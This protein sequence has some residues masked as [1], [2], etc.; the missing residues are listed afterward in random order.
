MLSFTVYELIADAQNYNDAIAQLER[1]FSSAP[2]QI[3]ARYLP[4]LRTCKQSTGQSV[5]E[6]QQKLEQL[7]ADCN[8]GAVTTQEHKQEAICDTF[9]RGLASSEIR[10]R[11]LE[12]RD[13]TMQNPFNK[14]QSLKIAYGN[15]IQYH[16]NSSHI[17]AVA[18]LPVKEAKVVRRMILYLRL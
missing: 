10:Q 17:L 8:F 1:I 2:S 15:A 6:Y 13:L 9:I 7:S 3:F 12:E 11:L 5:D 16:L 4:A 18:S 14:V